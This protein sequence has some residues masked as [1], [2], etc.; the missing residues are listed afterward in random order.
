MKYVAWLWQNTRGTRLN[1]SVRIALGTAQVVL[2]LLMVWLSKRFI[3][4]TIHT[5]S[6]EAIVQM[7]VLLA[8]TVLGRILLRQVYFYMTT[9]ATTRKS[10]ELRLSLFSKLFSRRLFDE[11]ELHSGDVTSRLSKDIDS[12]SSVVADTIPQMVVTGIQLIG[13]FLLMRFFDAWLAWALVIFTP[14]AII[15]GKFVARRLRRMTLDI[16]EKESRIQMHVQEGVEY[17]AVLRSLGSEQWMADRLDN[18]QQELKGNVLRRTRFSVITRFMLGIAFGFGYLAAFI[19]GGLGLYHGTITFGV[20]TSFLQLVGQIQQPILSLLNMTPQVIHSTASIDRLEELQTNDS[21]EPALNSAGTQT[22]NGALFK[23]AAGIRFDDVTFKYAKGDRE[24]ISH[25]SHDFKPG[26]KTA[27]MGETGAG[28]TTL[29]RLI[30]GFIEPASGNVSVYADQSFT[31]GKSTRANFIFVPQGNTLMSGS[32]RYNLLLAKPTAGDEELR[33][34]LHTACADFVFEFPLGLDT[35][36]GERGCG[37]SEGQ[38]QR[39]AIARG[40]LREGSVLL[41]DEISA[42]LDEETERELYSRLFAANPEKTML[43]ITHRSAV[44]ELCDETVRV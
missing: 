20:M 5:G 35:E 13:A 12:V 18:M 19:W 25:F 3:D 30:L 37:L 43:F 8:L 14:L 33:A 11:K 22:A 40:L 32:I 10:N 31:A 28:K 29:F 15:L 26:S 27:L 34:A 23:N 36:I 16:R 44:C 42:S 24:I 9:V 4:E 41:L 6:R 17:N 38:A 1:G 2:G 7:I 21:D 39:I